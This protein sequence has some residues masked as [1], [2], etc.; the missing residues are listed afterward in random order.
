MRL[1][2][3]SAL[4]VTTFVA[5][6]AFHPIPANAAIYCT[7]AGVPQGCVVRRGVAPR[8]NI[9]T[10]TGLGVRRGA[11]FNRGGPVNRRGRR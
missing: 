7:N 8:A 11:A 3:L 9:I 10:T 6:T 1:F 4:A 5:M 2:V